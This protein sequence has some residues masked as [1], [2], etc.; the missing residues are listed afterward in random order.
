M[1]TPHER[2]DDGVEPNEVRTNARRLARQLCLGFKHH[3][4]RE[5]EQAVEAFAAVD[6]VQFQH[7]SEETARRAAVAYVDALWAKD[8]VERAC[9]VDGEIDDATLARADWSDVRAAFAR[10][11][12]LVDMDARYAEQSTVAWRRHKVGGDYW[13]PMKRAQLHEYRAALQEPDYPDKPRYGQS[14]YGPE[15]ARYLLGVELHDT[16]EWEQAQQV[17]TPYF[18]RILQEHRTATTVASD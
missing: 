7:V 9:M 1:A 15:P 6:T 17:M 3:D 13:T 18:E 14:G 8:E 16:R 12:S 10:R 4:D 5:R 11:A 2:A